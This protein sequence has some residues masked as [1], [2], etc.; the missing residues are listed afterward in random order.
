MNII[1]Y[2]KSGGGYSMPDDVMRKIWRIMVHYGLDK[3]VFYTGNMNEDKFLG[4]VKKESNVVHTIW[5]ENGISMIAW[6]NGFGSNYAFG[7]FCCFPKT[8][9]KNSV[10]LGRK[11]LEYWFSFKRG[12]ESILDVI[13]GFTPANNKKAVGFLKKVGL[14][15]MG[16]IPHIKCGLGDTGMVFSYVTRE[17]YN[18]R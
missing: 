15:V 1:P 12:D 16:T 17:G 2:V 3:T 6:L 5:E 18:G 9:G 10:V 14:T 11:C 4:F 8:W 7:H 13:L